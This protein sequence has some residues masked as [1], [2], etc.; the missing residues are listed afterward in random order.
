MMSNLFLLLVFFT[1]VNEIISD[2]REME[3][4]HDE[5]NLKVYRADSAVSN[6]KLFKVEVIVN[7]G[8][9]ETLKFIRDVE[10]YPNWMANSEKAKIVQF[11]NDNSYTV[12][13]YLKIGP[14]K[15]DGVASVKIHHDMINKTISYQA[16]LNKSWS[17]ENGYNR[18]K[19][20]QT[21]WKLIQLDRNKTLII[22]QGFVEINDLLFSLIGFKVTQGL[23]NTFSNLQE[24]LAKDNST[25][26]QS[27]KIE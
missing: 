14:F 5:D 1:S 16:D 26:P 9:S 10:N 3:L 27:T 18:L 19:N 25:K 7:Q 12:H 11:T 24:A 23:I 13:F 15:K 22:Y 4:L 2:G 6:F 17:E 20:Y 21:R 8:L